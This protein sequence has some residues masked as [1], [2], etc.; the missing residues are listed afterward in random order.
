MG[1]N[2]VDKKLLE[3]VL[4][5]WERAKKS[6]YA[7]SDFWQGEK[8]KLAKII[9]K[10]ARSGNLISGISHLK[11]RQSELFNRELSIIA[12]SKIASKYGYDKARKK[13]RETLIERGFVSDVASARRFQN[14]ISSDIFQ[15]VADNIEYISYKDALDMSEDS[16]ITVRKIEEA[17]NMVNNQDYKNDMEKASDFLRLLKG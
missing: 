15:K 13:Q 14:I 11:K 8:S 7:T 4:K 5:R 6:N 3:K 16:T 10:K 1:K 17:Y 2:Y 12:K 9:G